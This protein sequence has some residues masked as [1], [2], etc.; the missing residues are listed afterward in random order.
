MSTYVN[1][2]DRTFFKTFSVKMFVFCIYCLVACTNVSDMDG[3]SD[4]SKIQLTHNLT[5]NA[6]TRHMSGDWRQQPNVSYRTHGE[7]E[8]YVRVPV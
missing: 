8:M 1:T 4:A 7:S 6:E 2:V 3:F 5:V